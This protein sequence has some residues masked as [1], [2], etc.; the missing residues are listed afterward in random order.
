MLAPSLTEKEAALAAADLLDMLPR[1]EDY[2]AR[3]AIARALAALAPKL[4][5]SERA[6]GARGRQDRARQ[7]WLL[8][9]RRPHG[10][11]R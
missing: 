1:T 7:D 11:A 4:P 6:T 10:P 8:P 3:E 9:K 5:D 2:L